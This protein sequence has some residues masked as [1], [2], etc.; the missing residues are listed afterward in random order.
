LGAMYVL[1]GVLRP[2]PNGGKSVDAKSFSF[3]LHLDDML[4]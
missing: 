4:A 1:N 3:P 2:S